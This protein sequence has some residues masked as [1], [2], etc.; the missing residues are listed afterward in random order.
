[1][2]TG[3]FALFAAA[4]LAASAS[5]QAA[6][7]D[8][9]NCQIDSM[10][11]AELVDL[12]DHIVEQGD[13]DDPRGAPLSRTLEECMRRYGWSAEQSELAM[14]FTLSLVGQS[15]TREILA[16][17]NIDMSKIEDAV[18]N[19]T[20]FSGA[21]RSRDM[22]DEAIEAMVNRHLPLIEEAL[23]GHPDPDSFYELVGQF[24]MF[25]AMVEVATQQFAAS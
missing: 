19:D 17:D 1:M 4:I 7:T 5:V 16:A 14:M 13:S 9:L 24:M 10:T 12:V 15:G 6:D 2:M 22:S 8:E 21:I 3:R 20:L 11:D 25:R 18:V 23:R